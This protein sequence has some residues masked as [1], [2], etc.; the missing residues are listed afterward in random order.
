MNSITQDATRSAGHE[1]ID[2][3]W[4]VMLLAMD[5]TSGKIPPKNCPKCN[6]RNPEMVRH[7]AATCECLLCHGFHAATLDHERFDRMVSALPTG[8]LAIR[9]GQPSQL[10][11]VDAEATSK[12]AD[13]PTGLE[14]INS[15]E[16]WVNGWSLPTT[17]TARSVSGGLHLYYSLPINTQ[18]TTGRYLPNI[19]IK[20]DPGYVGAVTPGNGRSWIDLNVPVAPA[21]GDM[22]T[23]LLRK[24][25][26][27]ISEGVS[28]NAPDGY[29]FE[30]FSADGCPDGFRD[31]FFNDLAYRLRKRGISRQRFNEEIYNHWLK[32][33]QPPDARYEMPWE[34]VEYKLERVWQTVTAPST[35]ATQTERDWVQSLRG[36]QTQTHTQSSTSDEEVEQ[37]LSGRDVYLDPPT[38]T[39]QVFNDV[40][41]WDNEH[42]TDTGN[43][44]RFARLF[45]DR[46]I[47]VPGEQKWYLWDG[48]RWVIDRLNYVMELTLHVI[49]DIRD[50]A[51]ASTDPDTRT[52]WLRHARST[53]SY[54]GRNRMLMS[55][56]ALLTMTMDVEQLDKDPWK[57]VVK[58]G[59]V[60]LRTGELRDSDPHDFNTKTADVIYDPDA[61]CPEWLS[62]IYKVCEGNQELMSYLQRA[63]GYTLTGVI[64]EQKFFFL[65]GIGSNGKNVFIDTIAGLMGEYAKIADPNLITARND[66]HTSMIAELR[67]VRLAMA[68]ETDSA[69]FINDQRIK[70]ITGSP[71]LTGR[72]MYKNNVDFRNSLKLW[73]L[74][75][76]YPRIKDSSHGIWRR[77]QIIP[78]TAT[79]DRDTRIA[80][81]EDILAEERSGI[82]NWMIE[83]LKRWHDMGDLMEPELI[84]IAVEEYREDE[85]LISAFAKS[86]LEFVPSTSDQEVYEPVIAVYVEYQLWCNLRGEKPL[87][88]TV[89]GR[90]LQHIDGVKKSRLKSINGR[91]QRVIDDVR[92]IRES[93]SY[94]G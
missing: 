81:Y 4:H 3:G 15:W 33:A 93:I 48:A 39:G 9:T 38:G 89:F 64:T 57:L 69:H 50:Q 87:T 75:N 83:G 5:S 32:C 29:D 73:I 28:G 67:G 53:E 6:W 2:L 79:F 60:D 61:K 76:N 82:L 72:L 24:R 19:D 74:G 52:R 65:H 88:S 21:S 16:S 43:G 10:L 54:G 90:K 34:N 37:P 8:S 20:A 31:Y 41:P 78:F 22:L 59:T 51:N 40:R 35:H 26:R 7:D 63:C 56:S 47:F 44:N 92:I 84:R 80:N 58:N 18:I 91:K 45:R 55:A 70:D 86:V 46:V 11:V 27:Q 62:H 30:L 94:P 13:E 49:D 71:M 66:A 85:D 36:T 17:L 12:H 25:Q 77:I 42:D 14:V 1:Y 23:W 68:S